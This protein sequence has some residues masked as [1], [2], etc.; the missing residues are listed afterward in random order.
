MI[1]IGF[2][3]T[4]RG[5]T[6]YQMNVLRKLFAKF[7]R[8]SLHHGDCIGADYHTHQIAYAMSAHIVVHPPK[9]PIKRAFCAGFD[10]IRE[11]KEYLDRN[12]DIVDETTFLVATPGEYVEQLRSGTWATIRYASALG[13]LVIIIFP[14]GSVKQINR[15]R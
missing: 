4:Q 5:L 14:D 2:T 6:L 15:R 7:S 13:R 8:P 1:P 9:D 12:H 10:E 3:G 11:E